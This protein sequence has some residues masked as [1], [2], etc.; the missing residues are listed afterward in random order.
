M[1]KVLKKAFNMIKDFFIDIKL[2]GIKIAFINFKSEFLMTNLFKEKSQEKI[3]NKK[4]M[5]IEDF[6]IDRFSYV[7]EKYKDKKIVSRKSEKFIWVF[8]Y[9]GIDASPELVK[10]CINSMI[11]N[12]GNYKVIVLD[13][14]NISNYIS[15]PEIILNKVEKGKITL[16][17]F[18][19]ILRCG[20]I[21]KYGG[22]WADSTMFFSKNIFKNFDNKDFNT[23]HFSEKTISVT[24][25]RWTGYFIG[26]T[27]NTFFD[28][29]YEFLI[30]YNTK[31]DV[32]IDYFILD[33]LLDIAYKINDNFKE[34]IDNSD[35]LNDNIYLL[36]K[37]FD[38][39]YSEQDYKRIIND[40]VFFKL[41]TKKKH[42]T[43]LDN[44]RL[45]NYGY[46]IDS[47]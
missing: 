30:E 44:N 19:D 1:K 15:I 16:T 39:I 47:N 26:G 2:F 7:I 11:N 45:S 34:L 10:T 3:V 40:G 37:N 32:L 29:L 4:T 36:N 17:H 46:F 38:N 31:Y 25:G 13:K 22:I 27:A 14:N 5:L 12:S 42:K 23:N 18:S 35:I 43:Y 8:W 28:F 41:S 6:L 9:Q 24:Q 33:Y 20:L 21:S